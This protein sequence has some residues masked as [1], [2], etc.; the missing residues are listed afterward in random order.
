[1]GEIPVSTYLWTEVF[2]LMA[3]TTPYRKPTRPVGADETEQLTSLN[4]QTLR[5][6]KPGE[7]LRK[8]MEASIETKARKRR[9]RE[10][11]SSSAWKP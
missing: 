2:F 6:G 9:S 11:P 8:K 7:R 10:V 1:M 3:N 5:P 4:A